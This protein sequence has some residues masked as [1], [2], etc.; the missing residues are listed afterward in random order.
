[1]RVEE[2]VRIVEAHGGE[3]VVLTLGPAEAEDQ[4]RDAMAIGIDRAILLETDG[5]E[6]D[7]VATA[8]AIV[9]AIRADEA[10]DGP[11]D[12]ILFGNE[13]ADTGGFQV[14]IRVAHALGRPVRDR[15]QGR[16][17]RGR[18]RSRCEQEIGGGWEVYEVPLP[19]VVDRAGGAQP[20]A[21]PVRARAAC[22]PKRKQLE[23][24]T[25]DAAGVAARDVAA[26]A[27]RRARRGRPRCS[28]RA[29]EAAAGRRRPARADRGARR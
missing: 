7:P 11:F 24:T 1:M 6:W 14:G 3:S 25:P 2:A 4:L 9:D 16:R 12:L 21:L 19:A 29:P 8:G 15:A 20:A 5:G 22:G 17:G 26:R 10:A 13:S 28:A 27:C 23:A 18:R